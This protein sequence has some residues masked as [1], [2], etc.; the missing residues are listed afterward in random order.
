MQAVIIAAGE[1]SRF[2]PLN[3]KH[4]SQFKILG[5]S[6][7]YW[8][9]K[10]L[11][12][13]D[14]KEI[15]VVSG[16]NSSMENELSSDARELGV[17]ISFIVQEKPL[18]TGDAIS[19]A[20]DLIKEPFFVIW[21]YKVNIGGIVDKILEKQKGKPQSVL[22]CQPT[23]RPKDFGILRFEG[24]RVVEIYE[25][26]SSGR[27][28]SRVKVSGTYFL[29]PDF[30]DYYQSLKKHHPDDFVDA[31]NIYL[32]AKDVV[33]I[34]SGKEF[35]SLKY[36]WEPLG[37]LREMM[38]SGK[39]QGY[40]SQKAKI[41]ENVVIKG[42]VFIGD[43]AV[44]GDNTVVTGPCFI[45]ENCKIG[46]S[47]VLRGPI[48]LEK[49]VFTGSFCELKNCIVQEGTHFHSGYI[50]D[51]VIGENCRFGAG[52]ITANRRMDRGSIKVMVKGEKID[53]G[54]TYLGMISGDNS[55]FGIH[56]GT[57][58]GVIIGK[59]CSIGPGTF[60][61]ENIE[62]STIFYSEFKRIKKE[63]SA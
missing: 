4:K 35:P 29:E 24:D 11:S 59:N 6:L 53:T 50:G 51:S 7:I 45:G 20:R 17:T 27:E 54:L 10:E 40:I 18:G 21:P 26:P 32:K 63:F 22:T 23:A 9:I 41:G 42:T 57:M 5:K 39:F 12:E 31:L 30:F 14:V 37:L 52:F 19:K 44:M 2:W 38:S 47:N 8:T 16:P 33:V 1:S 36:S 56:A 46:A 62:D 3:Q 49:G 58:P 43:N 61:F 13:K 60:V 25:N 55:K 48:D 34:S 15:I 28:P